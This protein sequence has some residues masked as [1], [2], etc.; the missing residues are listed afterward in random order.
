[1]RILVVVVVAMSFRGSRGLQQHLEL[2]ASQ[3]WRDVKPATREA[4]AAIE[5]YQLRHPTSTIAVAGRCA[6][7]YPQAVVMNPNARPRGFG[8]H[9]VRLTCPHLC[10]HI[11]EWEKDGAVKSQSAAL[12]P[13]C[14]QSLDQVNA[15]HA[16]TRRALV[17]PTTAERAEAE[18][19]RKQ[20]D[21]AMNSGIAG[22]SPTRNDDIKCVHAHVADH[23]LSGDNDIGRRLLRR[24]QDDRA[25]DPEGSSVCHQQCSGQGP[26]AYLPAKNK[27]KL[28]KTRERRKALRK[29]LREKRRLSSESEG[30]GQGE[31]L[32]QPAS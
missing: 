9:L 30:Q 26:W 11:D 3:G 14:A 23:L 19:G 20:F 12:L 31:A 10:Q 7:G 1:M 17:S 22:L 13:A 4:V 21:A 25:C 24:L 27:Q 29:H 15:R 5:S 18:L 28:W 6:Y 16:A 8:A 32:P 2:L